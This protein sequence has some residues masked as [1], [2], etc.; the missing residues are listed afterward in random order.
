MRNIIFH[1]HIFKNAGT[2]IDKILE[3]NFKDKLLQKEFG[4]NYDHKNL[5]INNWI[6][7]NQNAV[8][9]ASHTAFSSFHIS[10]LFKIFPIIFLRHPIARI[11][12]AYN[13]ERNQKKVYNFNTEL[14]KNTNFEG[15]VRVKLSQNRNHS[16]KNFQ[17]NSLKK[18]FNVDLI[19]VQ[20]LIFQLNSFSKIIGIVDE[21][22]KSWTLIKKNLD[23]I[24]PNFE[25]KNI[26][27]N[28]TTGL[29]SS[30]SINEELNL[31]KDNLSPSS[32]S[33]IYQENKLDIALYKHYKNFLDKK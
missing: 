25:Y 26:I 4:N 5:Q 33:K 1:Y 15:Y 11:F 9:F 31:I 14:A 8:A 19:N 32:Y 23:K 18:L 30:S 27:S 13:F 28:S 7:D 6:N 3:L 17:F 2:S 16:L 29:S 12:S 20:D 21:F 22:E 10:H 24:Y